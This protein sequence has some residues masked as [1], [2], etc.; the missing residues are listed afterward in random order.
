[1]TFLKAESVEA[2]K[3]FKFLL[4]WIF[5]KNESEFIPWSRAYVH[6]VP[7]WHYLSVYGV[8]SIDI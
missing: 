6:N 5:N 2:I 3:I 7:P 4:I 8:K 1:M